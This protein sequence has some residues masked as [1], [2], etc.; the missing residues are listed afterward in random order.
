MGDGDDIKSKETIQRDPGT[1]STT[2]VS[3]G[4]DSAD[5][6]SGS[7][8]ATPP[9]DV[10]LRHPFSDWLLVAKTK[11]N[12]WRQKRI[13][14]ERAKF[15]DWVVM[16]ATVVIAG[17]AIIQ[18][19]EMVDAGRQTDKIIAADKRLADAMEG[20]VTLAGTSL[21]ETQNSFRDD[22][23]AWI[24]PVSGTT[25][26]DES[27]P[28]RVDVLYSNLGKTPAL[29]VST[30]LSWKSVP[31]GQPIQ[32]EYAPPVK[33]VNSGTAYPNSKA[34][35]FAKNDT[36]PTKQEL[37]AIQ[38]GRTI[39]Y[40]FGS[41]DYKDVYGRKHWSHLCN[42]VHPDHSGVYSCNVYNDA[43]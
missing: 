38:S 9:D 17:A 1:L 43:N 22:Q 41:I 33:R 10:E 7:K 8:P 16:A 18:V 20:S 15:T 31:A 24:A 40:F 5:Q 23:R 42:V 35:M 39:F 36:V 32:I 30:I 29:E 25:T 14:R 6:E 37:D 34:V 12:L 19:L 3:Q 13:P 2:V 27:H 28:L 4:T 21:Q 11:W 26:L